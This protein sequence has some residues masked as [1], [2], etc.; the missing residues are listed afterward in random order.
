MT[1]SVDPRGSLGH[2]RYVPVGPVTGPDPLPPPAAATRSLELTDFPNVVFAHAARD[3]EQTPEIEID[4]AWRGALSW[5][6]AR[7]LEGQKTRPGET[8]TEFRDFVVEQ[9]RALSGSRQTPGVLVPQALGNDA[10]RQTL[11]ALLGEA[12]APAAGAAPASQGRELVLAPPPRL[13]VSGAAGAEAVSLAGA[14]IAGS[15]ETARLLWDTERGELV[16]RATADVIAEVG[17]ELGG[18]TAVEQAVAKWRAVQPLL[19]WA[20]KRPLEL[21]VEPDDRRYR[22]GDSIWITA[23]RPD[24]A[25]RYLMIV[26]LASTGEVQMIFPS[27]AHIAQDL[28]EFVPGLPERRLGPAPVTLPVGAD[29]V[30]ALASRTRLDG[31]RDAIGRID[32]LREPEKLLRALEDYAGDPAEVRVGVLPIFTRR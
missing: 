28:D 17:P 18:A 5:S 13:F 15:E 12:P 20:P 8:L 7:A 29:H 21:R 25:Y 23:T 32:G 9:V 10:A 26:N 14:E 22:L 16:D 2:S 24:E 4:G 31:L 6:V 30:V 27:T 19:R 1:R 11:A 3:E